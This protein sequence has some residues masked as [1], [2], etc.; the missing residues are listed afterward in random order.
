MAVVCVLT[1]CAIVA[2]MEMVGRAAMGAWTA[3]AMGLGN[4]LGRPVVKSAMGDVSYGWVGVGC[5]RMIGL[6]S[7]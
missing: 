2:R 6:R 5:A 1:E 4:D 3:R 7:W